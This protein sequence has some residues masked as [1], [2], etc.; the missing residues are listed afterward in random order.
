M[1]ASA[2][3]DNLVLRCSIHLEVVIT[4]WVRLD[5][6]LVIQPDIF[7]HI[8]PDDC[9][10]RGSCDKGEKGHGGIFPCL[11]CL[12]EFRSAAFGVGGSSLRIVKVMAEALVTNVRR[13]M[14]EFPHACFVCVS[15]MGQLF[16][17]KLGEF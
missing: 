5:G 2:A 17:V 14:E 16:T 13:V 3:L 7:D 9:N 11:F 1:F 12:C 10:G 6:Q 15:S 4:F 8:C